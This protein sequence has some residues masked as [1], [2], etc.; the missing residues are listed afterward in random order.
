MLSQSK[1][2]AS[3]VIDGGRWLLHSV[4]GPGSLLQWVMLYSLEIKLST[5]TMQGR[6]QK[7][8]M[9]EAMSN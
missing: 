4:T 8:I 1:S 6:S 5:Q 3:M 9:C 2:H 7:Q